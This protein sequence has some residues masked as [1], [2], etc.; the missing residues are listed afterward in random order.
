MIPSEMGSRAPNSPTSDAER[1]PLCAHGQYNSLGK[2]EVA[3]WNVETRLKTF[4]VTL[5]KP[6]E[7]RVQTSECD[8]DNLKRL[9]QVQEGQIH[10]LR[11]MKNDMR[12]LTAELKRKRDEVSGMEA[13]RQKSEARTAESMTELKLELEQF[14]GAMEE[15]NLGIEEV[16]RLV[17]RQAIEIDQMRKEISG[18]ETNFGSSFT[19]MHGT[20]SEAA[21]GMELKMVYLEDRHNCLG[22]ELESEREAMVVLSGQLDKV[23]A[24]LAELSDQSE[25][26]RVLLGEY[27]KTGTLIQL[28]EDIRQDMEVQEGEVQK[29]SETVGNAVSDVKDHLLTV[30]TTLM[31]EN[32][33]FSQRVVGAYNKELLNLKQLHDS[34]KDFMWK[35]KDI[36][37]E[38]STDVNVRVGHVEG[39]ITNIR[40]E[41]VDEGRVRRM[42]ISKKDVTLKNISR[43]IDDAFAHFDASKQMLT[44]VS[45]VMKLFLIAEDIQSRLDAQD[46]LDRLSVSLI[47]SAS[48]PDD[49]L[50][51]PRL[52]ST[53]RKRP[54][55]RLI[56]RTSMQVQDNHA[57]GISPIGDKSSSIG[58]KSSP[59]GDKSSPFGD[60]SPF[61]DLPSLRLSVDPNA[62][63]P[64]AS[65]QAKAGTM[66][67]RDV[68][69]VSALKIDD[70][71]HSCMDR[72]SL[73]D[74][75]LPAFKMACLT[76]TPTDITYNGTVV[77]RMAL[78]AKRQEQLY[79]V[80]RMLQS[81]PETNLV[82]EK[83]QIL[84][85][86]YTLQDI[87]ESNDRKV[88]FDEQVV[89]L[90][91][92]GG[93]HARN[94]TEAKAKSPGG[95]NFLKATAT[96]RK[97]PHS[98]LTTRKMSISRK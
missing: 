41:L 5:I 39:M 76:Y 68:V 69:P 42:E 61:G 56:T 43:K 91:M 81:A 48:P 11:E 59:I 2:D 27:V 65:P 17:E 78:L 29:L 38:L 13:S 44:R 36:L 16:Q 67:I 92:V 85:E 14:K 74:I 49:S 50:A 22:D 86:F 63:T 75:V 47:G 73:A 32:A 28:E 62:P 71:C 72:S 35:T 25:N 21:R 52:S 19:N 7:L 53:D 83:Q 64:D 24:G 33:A 12:Q 89:S 60:M 6:L 9:V 30:Q 77:S 1:L 93:L 3:V 57:G 90:D 10:D 82:K 23:S 88:E 51:L 15:K 80:G 45:D 34:T 37:E 54:G 96:S 94:S 97:T 55:R 18:M 95:A 46:T 40:E 26:K 98:T 4:A 84:A 31:Q 8:Y 87:Y 20:L 66:F 58:D 70:H 79:E